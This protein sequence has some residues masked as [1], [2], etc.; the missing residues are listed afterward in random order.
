MNNVYLRSDYSIKKISYFIILSLIPL[1]IAGF[2]KNGIRL[3]QNDLVGLFGL[4][5]PLLITLLGFLIGIIVNL[6]YESI[7][8]KNKDK[9]SN[10]IFSSFHPVYGLIVASIISIN[11]NIYLFIII[12]FILFLLS[13]FIKKTKINIIALTALVLIFIINLI[14]SFT[15][16]NIY[17]AT[18]T[19]ELSPLDYLIGKGSGGINTTYGL[20]LLISLIILGSKNYYKKMIPLFSTLTFTILIFGYAIY[21]NEIDLI[22]N[23]IFSNG[24]LFSFIYVATDP[25]S[26]SYTMYGKLIYSLLLGVFTF[27]FFLIEPAL[28]VLG[29]ILLVSILHELIDK[30]CLKKA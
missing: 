30:I 8:K 7:I 22:F 18:K 24:I 26:S 23:N 1:I 4:F 20:L 25:L 27:I 5:K 10:K 29:A 17:E 15:F 2:Y 12:T 19:F 21:Q 11:T 16:L 6:C 14:S 9:I 13:K 3:Y 28:A